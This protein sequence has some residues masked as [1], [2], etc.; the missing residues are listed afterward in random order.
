MFDRIVTEL[1]DA[2]VTLILLML[3]AGAISIIWNSY[4][5]ETEVQAIRNQLL[6]VKHTIQRDHVDNKLHL[7]QSEIFS[8]S[9]Q[10]KE[11][12]QKKKEVDPLYYSRVNALQLEINALNQQL[13][14]MDINHPRVND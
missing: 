3:M 4:T 9:Q 13:Q 2:P 6:D 10:I 12:E 14:M 11:D 8:L 5:P 1:K 7:D